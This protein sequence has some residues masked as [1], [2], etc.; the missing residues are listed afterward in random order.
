MFED[1]ADIQNQIIRIEKLF[2]KKPLLEHNDIN[3]EL[4]KAI[5]D[6]LL[7]TEYRITNHLIIHFKKA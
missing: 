3:K 2:L 7:Y 6:E 5:S 1:I 4:L